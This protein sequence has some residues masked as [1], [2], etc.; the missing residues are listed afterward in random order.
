MPSISVI[1][2]VYNAERTLPRCIESILS[3][4]FTD[5]ELL[6]IDDG[7]TDGSGGICDDYAQIDPRIVVVHHCNV[8]VS[9]TRNRGLELAKGRYV[10]FCDS[11]DY[12]EPDWCLELYDQIEEHHGY[13]VGC[14][15]Y[16]VNCRGEK[17]EKGQ[18]AYIFTTSYFEIWKNHVSSYVCT[19]IY[20]RDLL[21][22]HG[23]RFPEEVSFAEDV[24]FNVDYFQVCK[25]AIIIP[26]R[27][28]NYCDTLG[29]LMHKSYENFFPVYSVPFILRFPLIEEEKPLK[30]LFQNFI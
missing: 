5:L 18:S 27:L 22:E 24:A 12:V 8:G 11:D 4:S 26:K 14:N 29:S 16:R 15:H 13:F 10:M 1:V 2:P 19:K 28:Y 25:G 21:F 6:L 30:M 9:A 17:D 23:I 7:S 3:Q 20:N